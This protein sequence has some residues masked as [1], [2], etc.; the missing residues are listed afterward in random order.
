MEHGGTLVAAFKSAFAD[1]NVKVSHTV[2]PRI[3]KDCLGVHY[4][5]FTIPKHVKLD[6]EIVEDGAAHEAA[7]FMELLL[8]DTAQVL[9]S[10]SHENWK[11]YAA[12]TR[13]AFGQ[14]TAYYI[15]CMTDEGLLARILEKALADAGLSVPEEGGFPLII[16]KGINDFGKTVCFYLNYSDQEQKVQY[17]Y[18]DGM[19]LL[20][21]AA[22]RTGEY[23]T[24]PAW[25]LKIIEVG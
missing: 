23:F 20:T 19:D 15:G 24:V 10:Y 8:P 17:G 22:V 11:E 13:N 7:V 9:A 21:G 25:D 4:H 14:G 5:Q 2:Q 6:G 18:A 3:L 16:R 12:V 1:E